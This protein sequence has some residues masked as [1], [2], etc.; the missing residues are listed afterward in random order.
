[1]LRTPTVRDVIRSLSTRGH[2][3]AAKA[4]AVS[5][6]LKKPDDARIMPLYV[7]GLAGFGAWI[8]AL[9]FIGFLLVAGGWRHHAFLVEG[10]V[11]I[12]VATGLRRVSNHVFPVQFAL[13]LS[14]AGHA[15]ALYGVSE[16]ASS[17]F[18]VAATAAVLCA[19]LYPL[20]RDPVH[21]FL[22][23]MT[24]LSTAMCWLRGDGFPN[25]L[26]VLLAFEVLATG[27]LFLR[28]GLRPA[29]RPMAFAFAASLPLLIAAMGLQKFGME[30][31]GGPSKAIL[32]AGL[33]TLIAAVAGRSNLRR[34]PVVVAL[35]ATLLLG[36]FTAPGLLAAIGILVLGYHRRERLLVG[37][38]VAAFA[39]F[40]WDFYYSLQ[41]D[42]GTKSALLMASGAL[43][44]AARWILSRRPWARR[45]SA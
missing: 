36:T 31:G 26:Y 14:M 37:L 40:L 34:E 16:H 10:L 23:C 5:S 27:L 38:G 11:M 13:A 19:A 7:Q 4:P 17:I 43:L 33:L 1:M 41:M 30:S 6:L 15:F 25:G 3:D 44:L 21:R 45:E 24:A 28:P 9:C 2:F 18:P 42:L 32:A 35:G 29:I 22:S 20:Y 39:G 8:A 12:G